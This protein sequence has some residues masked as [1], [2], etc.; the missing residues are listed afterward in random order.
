MNKADKSHATLIVVTALAGRVIR[1]LNG[2]NSEVTESTPYDLERRITN[3]II[4]NK[5]NEGAGNVIK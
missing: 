4:V 1:N 2:N 3:R 5:D